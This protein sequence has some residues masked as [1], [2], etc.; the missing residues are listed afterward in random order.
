[1]SKN[2]QDLFL[3]ADDS[4]IIIKVGDCVYPVHKAIIKAR[5]PVFHAMLNHN[6]TEKQ[7][8]IINI[9]DCDPDI[10]RDFL[11]YLYS[12]KLDNISVE[13]V[14]EIF[15]ISDKY[16]VTDMKDGC[17]EFILDN[18]SIDIFVDLIS[19]ATTYNEKKLLT[20]ASEFFTDFEKYILE[21]ENWKLFLL[22]DPLK[23]N[24]TLMNVFQNV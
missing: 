8:G 19:L 17:V 5:S 3:N 14:F 23:A 24:D 2:L 13:N 20:V 7:E 18:L 11:L 1:M 16:R 9:P 12:G 10:F 6:M 21:S 4:D 15:R 22:N